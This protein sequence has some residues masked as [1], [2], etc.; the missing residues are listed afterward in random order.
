MGQERRPQVL[1]PTAP[2]LLWLVPLLL[3]LLPGILQEKN[4]ALTVWV[5]LWLQELSAIGVCLLEVSIKRQ[6][7]VFPKSN[8]VL[9]VLVYRA[10][11]S[12]SRETSK[13]G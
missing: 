10:S 2:P 5:Q 13:E 7:I 1:Y 11:K 12:A 3:L 6:L 4:T 9:P 8:L